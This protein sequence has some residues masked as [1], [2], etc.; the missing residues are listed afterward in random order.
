MISPGCTGC[1]LL[2]WRKSRTTSSSLFLVQ[3]SLDTVSLWWKRPKNSCC[4]PDLFKNITLFY[5]ALY[6]PGQQTTLAL[7]CCIC[8]FFP[9]IYITFFHLMEVYHE[10]LLS[11]DGQIHISKSQAALQ[12]MKSL[13]IPQFWYEHSEDCLPVSMICFSAQ[14]CCISHGVSFPPTPTPF[15]GF[16]F[17]FCFL[18]SPEWELEP[19]Q[20]A[21]SFP[22]FQ[23]F[24]H[25]CDSLGVAGCWPQDAGIYQRRLSI[26][27][28]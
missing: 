13:K 16:C 12:R 11:F 19:L 2:L 28:T 6:T 21:I 9:Q 27:T 23:P 20:T 22:S 25:F 7:F 26:G 4:L 3:L 8:E 14:R 24:L 10:L 1:T 5:I 15:Y 18:F 17:V